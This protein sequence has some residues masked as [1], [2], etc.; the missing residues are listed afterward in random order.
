MLPEDTVLGLGKAPD[1]SYL[2]QLQ[3]T[4]TNPKPNGKGNVR[5][6]QFSSTYERIGDVVQTGDDADSG[7][8]TAIH[9]WAGS[10]FEFHIV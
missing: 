5:G 6:L 4:G 9:S 7:S 2:V 8:G 3:A 10:E 1:T